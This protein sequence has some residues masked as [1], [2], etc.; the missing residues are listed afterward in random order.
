M[1]KNKRALQE[2]NH[3]TFSKK[4]KSLDA[5]KKIIGHR[6]RKKKVVMCHGTFDIVHPGHIRQLIYAKSKGDI[7]VVSI[8][9]DK[10]ATAGPLSPYVPQELRALNVAAFEIVDY[11]FLNDNPTSTAAIAALQPDYFVKGFEYTLKKNHPETKDEQ[12]AL[13]AYGGMILFS[14][15]DIPYTTTAILGK[16]KPNLSIDQLLVLMS[17][18]GISFDML[19]KTVTKFGNIK[20]HVVGDLIVD[21]YSRCTILGPAQKSPAFSVHLDDTQTYVGGAGVVAKH[22][23]SLGADVTF[24]TVIGKD[25]DGEFALTDL[26]KSGVKINVIVDE[27]RPT[28]CKHRYFVDNNRLLLQVDQ[29]NNQAISDDTLEK[30]CQSIKKNHSSAVICSDFRHGIFNTQ[31]IGAILAAIPKETLKVADSQVSNRWGNILDFSDFDLITPN[32]RESRFALGDQDTTIRPLAQILYNK[33]R[34]RYLI[35]KLGQNGIMVYRSP[36]METREFFYIDTF[37]QEAIDAVGAGD[38]LLAAAT[39]TL[40]ATKNIVQAAILGNLCAAMECAKLGNIPISAK[41]LI[42]ETRQLEGRA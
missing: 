20:V 39:L 8:T 35:L 9:I 22:L 4:V 38:A 25:D 29:L 13:A 26:K 37:V 34:C 11:V 36:G 12:E 40:V 33:A 1:I 15:G 30:M 14:P 23:Q 42:E 6:P 19:R 31:T 16:N 5:I 17:A 21:K 27:S 7:L 24:T 28:T 32:E 3:Q 10:Y 41:E 2:A 18:E